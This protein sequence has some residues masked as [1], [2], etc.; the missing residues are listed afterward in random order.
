LVLELP[1]QPE[2]ATVRPVQLRDA[3]SNLL[4]N[5]LKYRHPERAGV[6]MVRLRTERRWLTVEVVDNG[7]GVPSDKRKAIFERF[8]R[9]E[10]PGRGRAGGHGLGLAFVAEAARAHHGKVECREGIDGGARFLVR[11]R[12]RA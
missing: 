6:C 8:A 4:D 11:I 7:I 10:G 1:A 9:V 3:L 12:R 5:A 2:V